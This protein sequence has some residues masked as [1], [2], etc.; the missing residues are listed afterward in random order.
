MTEAV[1]L[2]IIDDDEV[3]NFI[4]EL[5]LKK[6]NITKYNV[7]LNGEDALG[8]LNKQINSGKKSLP[9]HV[10]LDINM[11]MVDGL[12]FLNQLNETDE[13]SSIPFKIAMLT[14]SVRPQDRTEALSH[15]QVTHFI[16]KPITQEKLEEFLTCK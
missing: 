14:T 8:Y 16:E 13:L 10:L 3:Q 5:L 7:I 11:P 1:H 6:I 2:L 9:T 12:A 15:K 4:T